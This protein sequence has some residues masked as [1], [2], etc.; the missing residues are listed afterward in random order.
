MG[1]TIL[2][3]YANPKILQ[4]AR[5]TAGY[6]IKEAADK[7]GIEE[8]KLIEIEKDKYILTM[9]NFDLQQINIRDYSLNIFE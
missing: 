4:W 6:S 7:L 9:N 5:E 8:N 1:E 3:V 2:A